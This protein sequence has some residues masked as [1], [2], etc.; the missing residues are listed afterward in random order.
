ML[1]T[2][3]AFFPEVRTRPILSNLA[4][5]DKLSMENAYTRVSVRA[6]QKPEIYK[7]FNTVEIEDLKIALEKVELR[8]RGRLNDLSNLQDTANATDES[9]RA[10]AFLKSVE[11]SS[12]NVWGSNQEREKCR[13]EA[14]SMVLKFGQPALFT[15]LT[16]NTD[17]GL[18]IAYYAGITGLKS[19]FDLEFKDM[20]CREHVEKVAMKDYC[21]SARLY[22]IIIN[23]FLT[24]AI[25][26]DP[27]SNS[28]LKEG[29][30]F[31]HVKAYYGMTETQGSATLH[32]HLLI[33]LHGPP[34]TTLQYEAQSEERKNSF[35]H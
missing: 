13:R 2:S 17:N 15:T 25:G 20:P 6:K 27:K 9:R 5:F 35:Q 3:N 1:N 19:L 23:T 8:R 14:F 22:D 32:C 12:V 34:M 16:P 28:P 33:W 30:L 10:D 4:V 18:T 29:G 11:I 7:I 24:T 26:W 31:G 21:A